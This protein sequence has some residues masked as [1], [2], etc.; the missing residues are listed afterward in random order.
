MAEEDDVEHVVVDV[1]L[2]KVNAIKFVRTY[3]HVK[4]A[5]AEKKGKVN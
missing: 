5:K 4:L 1:K 3:P 2:D